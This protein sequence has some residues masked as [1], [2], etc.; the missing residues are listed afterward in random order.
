M[1]DHVKIEQRGRV[2]LIT[3]NRPD[4]KNALTQEI[5]GVMAA[6]LR[7]ADERSDIGATVLTGAGDIFT[8]GNDLGDFTTSLNDDE[9][10]PVSRF[11]M[12]L[13]TIKKPLVGAVNGAAIGVGTTMLLHCDLVY[14]CE[15]TALQTPF[16]NLALVPEAA[17]SILLPR[18]VGHALAAEMFLL[19]K[20]LNADEALQAGILNEVIPAD[21]LLDH[22]MAKATALAAQAPSAVMATKALMRD[23]NEVLLERLRVEGEV[24]AKL[25]VTEEFGE[26]VAAFREKRK[27][28][29]TKFN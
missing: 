16:V 19:G 11:L 13:C 12:A 24:F 5:Y 1:S 21:K 26:A 3:I 18:R 20:T 22:A 6:A 7:D 25:L 2:Q 10:P 28:D 27:P 23:S 8:A 4:K 9:V 15:T 29:Y 17:S 14:G